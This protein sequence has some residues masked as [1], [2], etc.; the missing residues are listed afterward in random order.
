MD[1]SEL[2]GA[3]YMSAPVDSAFV[4]V[5]SAFVELPAPSQ[6]SLDLSST[7]TTNHRQHDRQKETTMR[8]NPYIGTEPDNPL[9]R[10][11]AQSTAAR[12]LAPMYDRSGRRLDEVFEVNHPD[13]L[14]GEP[15]VTRSVPDDIDKYLASEWPSMFANQ[16]QWSE[17]II[18]E[19]AQRKSTIRSGPG[20]DAFGEPLGYQRHQAVTW[21]SPDPSDPVEQLTREVI[22]DEMREYLKKSGLAGL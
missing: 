16:S 20:F 10:F 18:A 7:P 1:A 19:Q 13:R 22:R 8:K 9:D 15:S 3:I 2:T 5:D 6:Q 4:E 12:D 21:D 17:G 11:N 14:L